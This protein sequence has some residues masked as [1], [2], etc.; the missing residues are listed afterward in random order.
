M[1][2]SIKKIGFGGGCHWCT[3]AVFQSLIGVTKVEQGFIASS[4][5]N[6]TFSEAVIVHFD[7]KIISLHVLTEV[8]LHTHKSTSNHSMRSKYRSAIYIFSI[9]QQKETE[10]L[11]DQ[12]QAEFDDKIITNVLP[13]CSFKE[14]D[15]LFKNYYYKNPE[16]PFCETFI[17]PKLSFLLK[18][19]NAFV[20]QEKIQHVTT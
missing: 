13:F 3:E 12:I 5:E 10:T 8:H 18:E 4:N 11:L 2:G 20:N 1:N 15:A 7:P 6:D 17:N 16:K 19:Y 14:S 9:E